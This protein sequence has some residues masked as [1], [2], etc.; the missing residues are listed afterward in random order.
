MDG[1]MSS[2]GSLLELSVVRSSLVEEGTVL[3]FDPC[4]GLPSK[5]EMT[6]VFLHGIW[7]LE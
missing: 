4:A 1:D 2:Y 7:K 5:E 3:R 6:D